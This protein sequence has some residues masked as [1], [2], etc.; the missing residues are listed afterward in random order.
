MPL[1]HWFFRSFLKSLAAEK[2]THKQILAKIAG[3]T[4][5]MPSLPAVLQLPHKE[6][7]MYEKAED[8]SVF[9]LYPS[10]LPE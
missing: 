5:S 1:D 9:P 7:G 2:N 6:M 4:N 8:N 10:H 3:K